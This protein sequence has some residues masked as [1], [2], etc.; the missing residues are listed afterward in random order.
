MAFTA[1]SPLAQGRRWSSRYY[2]V[3]VAG[4][5]F[6][7]VTMDAMGQVFVRLYFPTPAIIIMCDTESIA[8]M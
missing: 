2:L 6:S 5:A 7:V 4:A 1:E 8:G 3:L